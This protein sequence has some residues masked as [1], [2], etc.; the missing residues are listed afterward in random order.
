[1]LYPFEIKKALSFLKASLYEMHTNCQIQEM[2]LKKFHCHP[3]LSYQDH[4]KVRP[5]A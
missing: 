3:L 4:N 5:K 2:T 1:M